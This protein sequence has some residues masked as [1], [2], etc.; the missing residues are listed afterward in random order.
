MYIQWDPGQ[1]VRH[2]PPTHSLSQAHPVRETLG[3]SCKNITVGQE[4]LEDG[5]KTHT[6]EG[7]DAGGFLEEPPNRVRKLNQ[8]KGSGWARRG[9][10]RRETTNG[11]T[12]PARHRL[13]R[14]LT[15][16][17]I[18]PKIRMSP[19]GASKGSWHECAKLNHLSSST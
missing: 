18:L 7:S 12:P 4:G 3:V 16:L 17:Q 10:E 8:V 6:P 2:V 15:T 1:C 13:S 14:K 9:E 5:A 19:N 11:K